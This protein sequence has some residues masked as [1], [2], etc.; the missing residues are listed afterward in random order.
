MGE[1]RASESDC[2][3]KRMYFENAFQFFN[4]GTINLEFKPFNEERYYKGDFSKRSIIV[5]V[6]NFC[7]P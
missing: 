4:L 2:K 3:V 6:F 7:S 1:T 5:F